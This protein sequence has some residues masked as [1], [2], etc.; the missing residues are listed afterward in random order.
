[1]KFIGQLLGQHLQRYPRMAL[2]DIY[3]LLHQAASA[4]SRSARSRCRPRRAGVR[5]AER[6]RGPADPLVD[7]ISGRM[8]A[9]CI[10]APIWLR[11]TT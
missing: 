7:P 1:M 6:R 10:C 3:K 4:R 9:R 8:L 2:A 5:T 11:S